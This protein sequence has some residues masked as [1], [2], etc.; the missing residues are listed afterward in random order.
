[1]KLIFKNSLGE[2]TL[3][4]AG[5]CS[6]GITQIDGLG[7]PSYE[8]QCYTS[9]DFDGAIESARRIPQRNI[10]VSGDICGTNEDVRDF[11][12]LLSEPFYM[13]VETE[14][15]KRSAKVSSASA[16]TKKVSRNITKFALSLVLDDPYFYDDKDIIVPL[17]EREELLTRALVLPS[18]FSKR[19]ASVSLKVTTDRII[20]NNFK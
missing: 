12:R 11:L 2:K 5:D 4:G 6:I 17:Y 19:T 8:R 1:M 9:Y 16:N 20:E 13:T 14:A 15:F 7:V 3:S 18:M 10:T